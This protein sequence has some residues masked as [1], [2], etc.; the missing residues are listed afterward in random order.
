MGGHAGLFFKD[1]NI[2]SSSNRP[3]QL[4]LAGDNRIYKY[5]AQE[6]LLKYGNLE[7][8]RGRNHT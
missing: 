1:R 3:I 4:A 5:L 8:L 2:N 6:I 7:L